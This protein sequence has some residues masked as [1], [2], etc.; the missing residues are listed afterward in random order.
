[1]ALLWCHF[2]PPQPPLLKLWG[3]TLEALGSDFV[4]GSPSSGVRL[5]QTY[6]GQKGQSMLAVRRLS[7][8]KNERPCA[9]SARL[10]RPVEGSVSGPSRRQIALAGKGV[11][12]VTECHT[13][14]E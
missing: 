13:S 11:D 2:V 4:F 5:S 14:S 3:Q 7:Y 10:E 12:H 9:P 6:K 8:T 1:M